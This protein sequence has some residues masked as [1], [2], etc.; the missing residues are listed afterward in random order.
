MKLINIAY[1]I[2]NLRNS[3][4]VNVLLSIVKHLDRSIF[5]PTIITL[6]DESVNSKILEFQ[7]LNIPIIS[8]SNQKNKKKS[9]N[10]LIKQKNIQV[11]HSHGI[12][13]DLLASQVSKSIVKISTLHSNPLE[14]YKYSF[15]ITKGKIMARIEFFIQRK[16]YT[17]TCSESI[18]KS[19]NKKIPRNISFIRNGVEFPRTTTIDD[20][21]TNKFLFIGVLNKGKNVRFLC[22]IFSNKNLE[23]FCLTIVGKGPQLDDLMQLYSNK[24]NINFIGFVENPSVFFDQN[25]HFISSSKTEGMPMVVL[26]ALSHGMDV[27]LSDIPSHREIENINSNVKIFNED[28]IDDLMQI[29]KYTGLTSPERKKIV[30]ES[31]KE[32][33]ASN[34]S[35]RYQKLYRKLVK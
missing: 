12:K 9:L 2:S 26:E 4:P 19:V 24:K 15:G 28:N 16:M 6:K 13:P 10:L 32:F 27:I 11:I 30:D 5:N 31:R 8:F 22:E 14:D 23:N 3:G 35:A 20:K 1:I 34:M 18:F 33:S 17:V 7:K 29:I 21:E 25:Q